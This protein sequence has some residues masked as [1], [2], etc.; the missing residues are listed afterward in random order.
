MNGMGKRAVGV[1]AAA[2][3]VRSDGIAHRASADRKAAERFKPGVIVN[4]AARR[5]V[6][7]LLLEFRLNSCNMAP[8]FRA[9]L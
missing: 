7:P 8:T 1:A 2:A 6:S 4:F 3:R 9:E 5:A